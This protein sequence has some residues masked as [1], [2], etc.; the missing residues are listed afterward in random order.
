[1]DELQIYQSE[2]GALT[3]DVALTDDTVWLSLDQ[4]T[5]LF[6]RNKSTVSRHINNI[7]NDDELERNS[8]VAK[9]ATTAKD[10]K[11]YLVDY[12]NLDVIISVG[13]R[14]KFQQDVK[15]RQ[16]ATRTLKQHLLH[17]YTLDKKRL[18]ENALELQKALELVKRAS[19]LPT[20]RA[21]GAGLIDIITKYTNT[22][23]W[24]SGQ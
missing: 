3:L 5:V 24:C 13:Y 14:V 8:V 4:M 2:D 11:T 23:L 18:S 17:G 15:F 6:D 21:M 1:M 12:F 16:W 22:S 10:S 20:H 19:A 9:N 7:F